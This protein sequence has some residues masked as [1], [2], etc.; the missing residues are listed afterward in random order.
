MISLIV[1]MNKNHLIGKGNQLPWHIKEDMI[2]F[3][4]YTL[5]KK[6]V[7]GKE[8]F[9]S[10]GK[11]LKDRINYVACNDGSFPTTEGTILVPD[12]FKLLEEY[13]NTTEE[14]VV[15]GGKSIY[16]LSLPYVEKM[17]ISI[18][19]KQYDGDVYFPEFENY[20]IL[21]KIE[22]KDEI[23]VYYYKRK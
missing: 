11:P 15:I 20:F 18:V 6:V 12:L 2:H 23:D 19:K 4:N 5:N 16:K 14:L 1:A 8:T 13:K 10:I 9:Y 21:E 17:I 22:E 3:K 7:M